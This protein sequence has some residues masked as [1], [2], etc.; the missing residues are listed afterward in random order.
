VYGVV[1][2]GEEPLGR[3]H[4]LGAAI[5]NK[6]EETGKGI[7]LKKKGGGQPSKGFEQTRSTSP[8]IP[9]GKMSGDLG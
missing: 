9:L 5:S 1:T 7:Q 3:A 6:S 2:Q 8:G 4:V